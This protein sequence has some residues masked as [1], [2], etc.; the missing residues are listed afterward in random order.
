M[1][2]NIEKQLMDFIE[3]SNELIS[4]EG[5]KG[6]IHYYKHDEY[7]MAFEILVL[8]LIESNKYPDNFNFNEWEQLGKYFKLDVDSVFDDSFW[9][10]FIYWGRS[11]D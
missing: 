8:E 4:T 11:F 1:S 3:L 9:D 6:V 2:R 7:E 10:K 5:I